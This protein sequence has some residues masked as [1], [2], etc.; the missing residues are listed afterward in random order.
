MPLRA[1]DAGV[2]ELRRAFDQTFAVRPPAPSAAH[3]DLLALRVAGD[4]CVVFLRDINGI[5]RATRIA[6]VPGA[7][8]DVLGLAGVRGT[9]VPV[10]A[11]ASLLGHTVQEPA[12]WLLICGT[13]EPLAFA[14]AAIDGHFQLPESRLHTNAH[15]ADGRPH[16]SQVAETDAGVRPVINIPHLVAGIRSRGRHQALTQE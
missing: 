5:L 3:V 13:D 1:L 11:L 8:A 15:H 16:I 7:P 14:V 6:S 9:L 10:F 4:P 12:R 2:A